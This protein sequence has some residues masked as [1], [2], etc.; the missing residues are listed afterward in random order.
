MAR[1]TGG[2]LNVQRVDLVAQFPSGAE[3]EPFAYDMAHRASMDA[4]VILAHFRRNGVRHVFLRSAVRP[5][6]FFRDD[7]GGGVGLWELPAGLIDAGE[8]AVEAAARELEEEIGA[9][10]SAAGLLPLGGY[11]YPAPAMIGERHIFFQVE[12]DPLAVGLPS[13]DGSPLEREA[14]IITVPI[15]DA[16]AYCRSGA[17]RDAKTELALYRF[18]EVP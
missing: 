9:R 11:T 15:E 5:P 6:V 14:A 18:A 10:V 3:S 17:I 7:D 2:F 13:E 1:A 8:T 16:M 12:V 4:V